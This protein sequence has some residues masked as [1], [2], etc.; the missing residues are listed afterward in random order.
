MCSQIFEGGGSADKGVGLG[1]RPVENTQAERDKAAMR[2][3]ANM[4]RSKKGLSNFSNKQ[5]KVSIM[6]IVFDRKMKTRSL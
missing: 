2:K 1:K 6:N 4:K 5:S 3:E